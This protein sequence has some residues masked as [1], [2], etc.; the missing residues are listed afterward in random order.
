M[1]LEFWD[2]SYRHGKALIELNH[3][4]EFA[5]IQ[6]IRIIIAEVYNVIAVPIEYVRREKDAYSVTVI[7]DKNPIMTQVGIGIVS[8][9]FCEIVSGLKEGDTLRWEMRK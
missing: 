8:E 3:P 4:H 6:K 9:S 7:K 5:E 1:N 2:Y